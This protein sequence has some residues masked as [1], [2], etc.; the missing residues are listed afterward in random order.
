MKIALHHIVLRIQYIISS[1]HEFILHGNV[2]WVRFEYCDVQ[3]NLLCTRKNCLLK[4]RALI[5]G[6]F[7][8]RLLYY[9]FCFF[10][11]NHLSHSNVLKMFD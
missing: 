2:Q 6:S 4:R 9:I 1:K 7:Q 3:T 5:G 8:R 11:S 10:V